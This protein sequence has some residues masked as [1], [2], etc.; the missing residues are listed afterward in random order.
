MVFYIELPQW[1][2]T[3]GEAG[4]FYMQRELSLIPFFLISI[5][6]ISIFTVVG[7]FTLI[8]YGLI[9]SHLTIFFNHINR[10]IEFMT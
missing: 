4:F 3:S 5:R 7:A 1:A 9:Q 2:G 10:I 6:V 8:W